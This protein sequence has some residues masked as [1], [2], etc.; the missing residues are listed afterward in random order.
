MISFI[1]CSINPEAAEK[2]CQN[3][4]STAGC[5]CECIVIDNKTKPRSIAQ[6]Y[7][8]GAHRAKGHVLC[9]VHEDVRFL[10]PDFGPA[11]E[12]KALQ[13]QTGVIGFLGTQY[14]AQAPSGWYVHN[15]LSVK[16]YIQSGHRGTDECVTHNLS[17]D[18]FTPVVIVDGCCM[19]VSRETWASHPFDTLLIQGFH[20]YDVDFCL[21]LHHAGLTNYVCSL[22]MMEHQSYGSYNLQWIET[23]LALHRGKWYD[24]LPMY[25]KDLTLTP[26]QQIAYEHHAWYDFL[27]KCVKSPLPLS[28]F[29][30]LL[31]DARR[32]GFP[33]SISFKLLYKLLYYRCL[34]K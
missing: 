27:K 26:Q 29:L 34:R 7:N 19:F 2:V 13:P 6:V 17:P 23:T 22:S 31:K 16:H 33:N 1:L 5:D 21:T 20:C 28:Q 30:A 9:F 32:I 25:A 18:G 4:R 24:Q 10:T 15:D 12:Q 3:I 14:K 8:E 11:I